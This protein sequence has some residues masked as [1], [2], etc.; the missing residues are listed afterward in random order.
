MSDG[1]FRGEDENAG[2]AHPALDLVAGLFLLAIGL[3]F[4]AMSLALP[5]PGGIFSAPGLLPFLT[6][7]SLGVMAVILA[8][9]GIRGIRLSPR[10][11]LVRTFFDPE[12]Q[13]RTMLILTVIVYVAAL[14]TLSFEHYLALGSLS[15]PVGSFEPV[16]IVALT[17]MLRLFWTPRL[18]HCLLVSLV[19]TLILAFTFRGVFKIPMPG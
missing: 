14:D 11:D 19:W 1:T 2:A 4:A 18:A 5:V 15:V 16:T 17:A 13:R 7:A 10:L 6:A 3:W 9:S 8:I 12:S